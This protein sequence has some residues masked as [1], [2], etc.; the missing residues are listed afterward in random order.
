M[1]FNHP[2]IPTTIK[3]AVPNILAFFTTPIFFWRQVGVMEVKI[4]CPN[5]NC[6]APPGSYLVKHGFGSAKPIH[7][8]FL[9]GLIHEMDT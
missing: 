5:A 9:S 7:F 8:A 2:P 4:K 1:E 6:L 3:G